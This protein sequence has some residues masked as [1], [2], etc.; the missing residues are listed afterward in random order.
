MVD[1]YIYASILDNT[2]IEVGSY[3]GIPTQSFTRVT[4]L[5]RILPHERINLEE[6]FLHLL[7]RHGLRFQDNTFHPNA[8]IKFDGIA[9]TFLI[10]GENII[11]LRSQNLG[12][13]YMVTPEQPFIHEYVKQPTHHHHHRRSARKVWLS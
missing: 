4:K 9:Q 8:W 10:P 5:V 1:T 2:C 13:L 3:R 12:G 6:T 7:D 11:H